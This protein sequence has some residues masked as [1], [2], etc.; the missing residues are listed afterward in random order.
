MHVMT[1]T[2]LKAAVVQFSP[3][4]VADDPTRA[5]LERMADYVA[6]AAAQD[7]QLVVFPELGTCGYGIDGD[8]V[9]RAVEASDWVI[10]VRTLC[11][12]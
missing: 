5:N 10:E 2:H 12:D 8:A 4:T 1:R 6:Q 9:K 11:C 7:A 3:T